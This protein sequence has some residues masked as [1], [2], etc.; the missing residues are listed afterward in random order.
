MG[1]KKIRMGYIEDDRLRV[2][3]NAKRKKGLLKKAMELSLLCGSEILLIIY[4]KSLNRTVMY[5]SIH[6][7]NEDLF[8]DALIHKKA[9]LTYSN[10]DVHFFRKL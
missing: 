1:R 8:K 4:E 7:P 10:E 3:T 5:N 6:E 2:I 9:T